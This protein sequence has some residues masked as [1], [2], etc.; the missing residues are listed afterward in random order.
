MAALGG[1]I[2]GKQA[3][4]MDGVPATGRTV[5]HAPRANLG[6][7]ASGHADMDVPRCGPA[8]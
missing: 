3:I 2:I 6:G 7:V 8:R 4:N 5:C 1:S